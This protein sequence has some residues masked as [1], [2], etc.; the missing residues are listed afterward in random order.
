[1][2]VFIFGNGL[3]YG[4]M[5]FGDEAAMKYL[6]SDGFDAEIFYYGRRKMHWYCSQA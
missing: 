4:R 6:Q 2:Q 3:Q 5:W 1:M